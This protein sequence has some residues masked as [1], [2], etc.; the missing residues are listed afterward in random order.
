M[1]TEWVKNKNGRYKYVIDGSKIE[2]AFVVRVRTKWIAYYWHEGLNQCAPC[3]TLKQAKKI[4]EEFV[5]TKS[6]IVIA[7]CA[8]MGMSVVDIKLTPV[9]FDDLRGLPTLGD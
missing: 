3:A 1:K 5:R 6:A 2:S 7:A 4:A 8:S 9:I